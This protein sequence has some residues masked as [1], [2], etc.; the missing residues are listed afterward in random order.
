MAKIIGKFVTKGRLV[1]TIGMMLL[2]HFTTQE[3][4]RENSQDGKS[5]YALVRIQHSIQLVRHIHFEPGIPYIKYNA[6]LG[7]ACVRTVSVGV[8][9]FEPPTSRTRTVRSTGLSHTPKQA[10]H[11]ESKPD[12]TCRMFFWQPYGFKITRKLYR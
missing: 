2:I 9:G 8:R 1:Q 10:F 7:L 5:G 6:G 3:T 11:Q 12:Y 4:L